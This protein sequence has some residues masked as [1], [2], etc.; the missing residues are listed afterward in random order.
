MKLIDEKERENRAKSQTRWITAYTI[1]HQPWFNTDYTLTIIDTPGF[2]D[3]E[4]I[5]RDRKLMAQISHF[6]SSANKYKIGYI[7]MIGFV[8]S[9]VAPRLTPTQNYI[10][11]AVLSIFGKD[12]EENI[13]M[14]LTFTDAQEPQ[15]LAALQ[16]AQVPYQGF[17]KFNNAVVFDSTKHSDDDL[18]LFCQITW[19]QTFKNF[20]FFMEEVKKVESKTLHL[21]AEVVQKRH[22]LEMVANRIQT[23]IHVYLSELSQLKK[24]ERV[25]KKHQEDIEQNRN[26][27]YTEIVKTSRKIPSRGTAANC[28]ICE[29]SCCKNCW[30]LHDIFLFSCDTMAY[31]GFCKICERKCSWKNH[32]IEKMIYEVSF[33]KIE[34]TDQDLKRKYKAA[35]ERKANA[36]EMIRMCQ[37]KIK[38]TEEDSKNQISLGLECSNRLRQ[39]AL[40]PVRLT[41]VQ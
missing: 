10:L 35:T 25:L 11:E 21:S 20:Y 29:M 33:K 4:G 32:T 34:R 23:N 1:H 39:I 6:F 37:K 9:S 38:Q 24:E 5:E 41:L 28:K 17:F 31:N 2:G 40:R 13:N 12:I 8:A 19:R 18:E 36:E 16:R 26:F 22:E 7:H 30:V 15:I 27:T 3:T 14:L